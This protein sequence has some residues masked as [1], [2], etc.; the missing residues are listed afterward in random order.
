[1]RRRRR[2]PRGVSR[3]GG[4]ALTACHVT[5]AGPRAAALQLSHALATAEPQRCRSTVQKVHAPVT[6]RWPLPVGAKRGA[7]ASEG[8]EGARLALA[9]VTRA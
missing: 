9:Q 8:I 1:M 5:V 3:D 6:C 2:G 4:G 7:G